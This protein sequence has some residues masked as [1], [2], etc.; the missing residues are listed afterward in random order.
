MNKE[1]KA[2]INNMN[3]EGEQRGRPIA[4]GYLEVPLI[5]LTPIN[6]AID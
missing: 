2:I 6:T 3:P 5:K 1:M 4:E